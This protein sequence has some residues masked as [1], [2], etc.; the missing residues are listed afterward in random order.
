MK[1]LLTPQASCD[2]HQKKH[3]RDLT[4]A[5]AAPL[6][7]QRETDEYVNVA[8]VENRLGSSECDNGQK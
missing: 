3:H 7:E 5:Q 4:A 1:V 8:K 6:M 2:T